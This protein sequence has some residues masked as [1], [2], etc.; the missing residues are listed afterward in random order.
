M[1]APAP[2]ARPLRVL[3]LNE[4]IGG[5][6]TVHHHLRR[7][8][9][10]IDGVDATFV[11]VP[12]PGLLRKLVGAQVPGL[13]R[14]DLDLQ[15]LRAQLALSAW[16][17]RRLGA[18]LAEVDVVHVYTQNS[19]LLSSSVLAGV[20]TVLSTDSTNAEN[21]YRLPYRAPTRFTCHT[22][23]LAARFERRVFGAVDALIANS[24]W[25]ARSLHLHY[26][27]DADDLEVLPFGITAPDRTFDR[28]DRRRPRI[29]FVGRQFE[30]KGGTV[31][32]EAFARVADRADLTLVTQEAPPGLDGVEVVDDLHQGDERL[33]ELL[34]AA[35]V[36][37]FPSGIDQAPNA[38]L[39]AMAAGLPVVAVDTA[40][41]GEMVLD[42]K[43]GVLI[44]DGDVAALGDALERLVDDPALRATMGAAGRAH[45]DDRYDARQ[46]TRCLVRLLADVAGR[47]A[48]I[49]V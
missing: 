49:G 25:V 8:I 46:A 16:V 19:V 30:R 1:T 6:A 42:G 48:P 29:V 47:P 22:W 33:W 12:R 20:P 10:E 23:K 9:A 4:N 21:A 2:G 24:E 17:R 14:L 28:P 41:V 26:G 11:D 27:V 18:L 43:T 35:D 40:A 34:A 45:F 5:H 38:V 15:P 7:A 37:A 3:F 31:L 13:A 36:F 39:E 44:D 32:L